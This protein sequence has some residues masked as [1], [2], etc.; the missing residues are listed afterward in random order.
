M[1]NKATQN[2]LD[3]L[4]VSQ[5]EDIIHVRKSVRRR[6]SLTFIQGLPL[7]KSKFVNLSIY[8]KNLKTLELAQESCS[9]GMQVS[10]NYVACK[11][12]DS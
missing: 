2:C 6:F 9:V 10:R 11:S 1:N 8:S 7:L 4:G 5:S 12:L 3:I